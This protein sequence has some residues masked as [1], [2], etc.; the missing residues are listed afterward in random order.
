MLKHSVA[1][2]YLDISRYIRYSGSSK[3]VN[4]HRHSCGEGS[5]ASKENPVIGSIHAQAGWQSFKCALK[6]NSAHLGS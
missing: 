1:I 4:F 5:S 3:G 2:K 6:W